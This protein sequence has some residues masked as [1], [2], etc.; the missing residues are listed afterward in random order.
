MYDPKILQ[1]LELQE[2]DLLD[3]QNVLCVENIYYKG[4][5]G[6]C[7]IVLPIQGQYVM[8]P[9]GSTSRANAPLRVIKIN[10][11]SI[12]LASRLIFRI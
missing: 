2:N 7:S 12:S 4:F 1:R 3:F 8:Y 10:N 5:Y 6:E 11:L 9:F